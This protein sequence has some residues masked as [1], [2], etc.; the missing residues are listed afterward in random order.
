MSYDCKGFHSTLLERA[1]SILGSNFRTSSGKTTYLGDGVYFFENDHKIAVE[2]VVCKYNE[3]RYG[4]LE[5]IIRAKHANILDVSSPEGEEFFHAHRTRIL[6]TIGRENLSVIVPSDRNI[7]CFV[8][9][10]ICTYFPEIQAVRKRGFSGTYRD[11]ILGRTSSVP[12]VGIICIRDV[13]TCIKETRLVEE[14]DID[15]FRRNVAA[16]G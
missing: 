11:K 7:D 9:N 13:D 12:N 2:F 14:G 6:D 5:S 1:K 15:E 10:S 4:V 3:G 16:S 8:I